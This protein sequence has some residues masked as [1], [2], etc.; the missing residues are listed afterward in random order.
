MNLRNN[1]QL[2]GNLGGDP[3]VKEV[4]DTKVANFSVAVSDYYK[5]K[6]SEEFKEKTMWFSIVAWDKHAERIQ[7]KCVKGTQVIISGKLEN[8]SYESKDGIKRYVTEVR[9]NEIIC[10]PKA[11]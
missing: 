7:Q 8:K 6:N 1:V 9:V 10:R 3:T 11:A 4:N 5:E 2:I